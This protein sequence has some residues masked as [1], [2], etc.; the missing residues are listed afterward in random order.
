M[1]IPISDGL[2]PLT[3]AAKGGPLTCADHDMNIARLLDRVNHTGTQP[4]TTITG[5]KEYVTSWPEWI[6]LEESGLSE[7]IDNLTFHIFDPEG[8]V[9]SLINSSEAQLR[10]EIG[11][12][13]DLVNSLE[14]QLN[15]LTT[16]VDINSNQ[17][18]NHEQV[19][20]NLE[21]RVA[22]NEEDIDALQEAVGNIPTNGFLPEVAWKGSVPGQSDILI[23]YFDTI[24]DIKYW[25]APVTIVGG[26]LSGSLE[27]R[28]TLNF[29]S[30]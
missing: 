10:S 24:N 3:I 12:I 25:G 30:L 18:N 9:Q 8:Q 21:G 26:S 11:P 27:G 7:R 28:A 16:R 17:I 29:G 14:S 2:P 20:Q 13:R 23:L 1:T 6:A 22:Q 5:L 19:L 15:N 4:V